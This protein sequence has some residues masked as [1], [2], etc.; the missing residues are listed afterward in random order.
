MSPPS[1][2]PTRSRHSA[3]TSIM[4]S[5]R[6]SHKNSFLV[7]SVLIHLVEF[8]LFSIDHVVEHEMPVPDG[9]G[10]EVGDRR[11]MDSS[12]FCGI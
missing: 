10:E 1:N 2:V 3:F 9:I 4:P 7:P 8:L 6:G 5:R 11:L 12:N